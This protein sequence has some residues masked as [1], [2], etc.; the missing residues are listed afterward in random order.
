M[1]T[2]RYELQPEWTLFENWFPL[3]REERRWQQSRGAFGYAKYP[4][5]NLWH[6]D[7]TIVVDA[8]LP[9][10]NPQ[11]VEV[12]L[13]ENELT[14]SGERPAKETDTNEVYHRHE[15]PYGRFARR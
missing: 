8:E 10:V 7:D 14:I 9:G 5:V 1:D 13:S 2:I 11:Q 6:S 4:P 15:R 3:N 12:T